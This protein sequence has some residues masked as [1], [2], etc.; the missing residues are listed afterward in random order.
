MPDDRKQ[1]LMDLGLETLVNTLLELS[2]HIAQVDDKI[3][4]LI[5]SEQENLERFRRKL[6]ALKYS[7]Q[8]IDCGMTYSFARVLERILTD[9]EEGITEP[10]NGLDLIAQFFETDEYVFETCDDSYGTVAEVYLQT[11]RDL[12]FQYARSCQDAQK[13]ASLFVRVAAKDAYGARSSLMENL[14]DFLV[15]PVLTLILDTLQISQANEKDEKKKRSYAWMLGCIRNQQEEANLFSAALQG[16]Q[17]ELPTPKMLAVARVFLERQDAESALAWVKRIPENDSCNR[18]EIEEILKK[19]YAMQGDRESLIALHYKNFKSYRTLDALENLLLVM[20]QEK[21]E[22]FLASEVT[23]IFQNPSF[24]DQD[25]HFLSDVGMMDELETYIFDRLDTLDGLS[26]Y[27][28]PCIAQK[29]GENGRYLASSLLYRSLLDSMMER[30]YA[31]SYHH[32]V[33]Y[34]NEMDA[35]APLVKDW[36]AFPT[37]NTYKMNLLLEHKRKRSFWDQYRKSKG[38]TLQ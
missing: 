38:S 24:D 15:E 26:Y 11:A 34:L 14:T 20:G 7:T 21:R 36:K 5:A 10:S 28:L 25:A 37:H 23:A 2:G 32:G 19:L 35:F 22:E 12:F 8:F 6:L 27:I 16:K 31:K 18:Y 33:D 9:I 1:K 29:L 3:N 17:V 4:T 13:V 30:A